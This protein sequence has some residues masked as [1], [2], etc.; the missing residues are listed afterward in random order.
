MQRESNE[1]YRRKSAL[2]L[3]GRIA[4]FSAAIMAAICALVAE[5]VLKERE[6]ALEQARAEAANL[7]ASF[8]E[9]VHGT[10][11]G[12]AGAME[13]LK[14]GGESEGKAF[15]LNAWKAKVPG[16]LSPAVRILRL[17][18]SGRVQGPAR[19]MDQ[20][21]T[22][23][24]GRDY[25][26][27]HRDNPDLGLYLGKPVRSA[28]SKRLVI[29]A[30]R[31]LNTSDGQFAGVLA[32]SVDPELLTNLPQKIRLGHTASINLIRGDGTTLARYT[33]A[34]GLDRAAIGTLN[35]EFEAVRQ[36]PLTS[37][38]DYRA[39]SDRDGVTRLYSW[40]KVPGYP[41]FVVA[42][43]GEAEALA[44]TAYR[45]KIIIGLG[46]AALSLPLIMMFMLNREISSRVEHAVALDREGE[47]V[48]LEHVALMAIT[49]ELAKERV[50]LRKSNK[51]LVLAR[52]RAEEANRT[53]SVF[54]ANM[55][56]ELRTPL[57]AV[58]GFSEII[59]DK[60]FGNDLGRYSE[61]AADI[62][63][64]GA[65]LLSI[66]NDILDVTRIEAGKYELR[67]ESVK[68]AEVVEGSLLA[69]EPQAAKGGITLR[70]TM[71]EAAA[72]IHGD[73]T[74]LNQ[75][76]INLLSNAIKFTPAGGVV[77]ISGR[78]DRDG[79]LILSVH[80]T[81]IGMASHEIE[82]A[83]QLFRQVDSS[84]SRRYEGTG[85]GLPLAIQ[86]TELHG[87]TLTVE[88]KP[89]SGTLVTVHLPSER[90]EWEAS[91]LPVHKPAAAVS[92]KYAS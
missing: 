54:L 80:D 41:L 17:D 36:R 37:S 9:Q 27:A 52:R 87:G 89:G 40:R 46:I 62:H 88:S 20:G 69:V 81:G 21:D 12:L 6:A 66:V 48:H 24:S 50:K 34:N 25:F 28:I 51:E 42:G 76:V 14:G 11:N 57:N 56:H 86:L 70:R 73:K 58:L 83:V 75:I 53:K 60:L 16:L 90:V 55:S 10:L 59:R 74:K 33:G 82:D 15:D 18:A 67:E 3:K 91:P 23:L 32:L 26:I 5:A 71:P 72:I 78:A 68:L 79:S 2:F 85:L 38:G 4:A 47:K 63:R 7:S 30:T 39:R 44:A 29:P 77:E 45:A 31:R 84:L 13:L 1:N 35:Q 8:E 49:E 43:I 64:S 61:Y 22:N 65:H 92:L 19:P